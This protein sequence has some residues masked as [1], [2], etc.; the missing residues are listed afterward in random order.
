MT[1]PKPLTMDEINQGKLSAWCENYA[2]W[3]SGLNSFQNQTN[4]SAMGRIKAIRALGQ[5]LRVMLPKDFSNEQVCSIGADIV[6]T[7][8]LKAD[9]TFTKGK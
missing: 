7:A 2:V 8:K 4:R 6:T 9:A 5:T 1:K 3:L